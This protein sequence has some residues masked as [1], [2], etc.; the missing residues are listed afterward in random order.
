MVV[1]D[2][3][4]SALDPV[5]QQQLLAEARSL[6]WAMAALIH[7][8]FLS[9][10][11]RAMVRRTPLVSFFVS[12]HTPVGLTLLAL[13]LLRVGWA[14]AMRRRRSNHGAGLV[15][16]AARSGH[17]KV[18][19]LMGTIPVLGLLRTWGD[20][21]PLTLAAQVARHV[22]MVLMHDLLWRDGTSARMAGRRA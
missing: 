11:L 14:L 17:P 8:Q 4:T 13:F 7:W 5:R 3:P 21:R 6:H 20:V 18:A 19:A 16:R 10:T 9:M 12:T 15:G 2:E 1:L 22:A